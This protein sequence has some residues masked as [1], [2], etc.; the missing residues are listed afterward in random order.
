[1]NYPLYIIDFASIYGINNNWVIY[2]E[3]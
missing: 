1:L 3:E 2:F